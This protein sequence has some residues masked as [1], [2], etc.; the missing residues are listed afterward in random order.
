[1][2]EPVS[3]IRHETKLSPAQVADLFDALSCSLRAGRIGLTAN[4]ESLVLGLSHAVDLV[5]AARRKSGESNVSI[6]LKW[7]EPTQASSAPLL[8]DTGE[9]SSTAEIAVDKKPAAKKTTAKKSA[10][11]STTKSAP[12][13]GSSKSTTSKPKSKTTAATK[14]GAKRSTTGKKSAAKRTTAAKKR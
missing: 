3:K 9:Q 4:E 8:I 12:K 13:K 11:K 10:V 14:G 5:F 6:I 1:M 2:P 7:K